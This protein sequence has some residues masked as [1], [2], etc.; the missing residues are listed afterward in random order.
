MTTQGDVSMGQD[1]PSLAGF[2]SR[3]YLVW[4]VHQMS[5]A[6]EGTYSNPS[7]TLH[8]VWTTCHV[9]LIAWSGD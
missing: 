1:S 4:L 5:T 8:F 7:L 2:Q 9:V 3:W 6:R